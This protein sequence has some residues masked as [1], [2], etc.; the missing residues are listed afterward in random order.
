MEFLGREKHW[1]Y[2]NDAELKFNP[3]ELKFYIPVLIERYPAQPV[4]DMQKFLAGMV[5]EKL[6]ELE[7]HQG[8]PVKDGLLLLYLGCAA[9]IGGSY[10]RAFQR[11][12]AAAEMDRNDAVAE[13]DRG[14]AL[15]SL[16]RYDEALESFTR[17]ITLRPEFEQA[18]ANPFSS[19]R[20]LP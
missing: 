8:A 19:S 9:Y 4:S 3:E 2:D 14:M 15:Q 17:A 6:E 11:F 16:G 10:E 5:E 1:I 18:W 7:R 13:Y 20:P 12:A